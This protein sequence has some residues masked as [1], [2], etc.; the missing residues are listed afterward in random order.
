MTEQPQT[1]KRTQVGGVSH[2]LQ[3]QHDVPALKHQLGAKKLCVLK[4]YSKCLEREGKLTKKFFC[5]KNKSPRNGM[6]KQEVLL[7][8]YILCI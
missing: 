3:G 2:V 7:N 5:V 6:V 4:I 8:V 1:T